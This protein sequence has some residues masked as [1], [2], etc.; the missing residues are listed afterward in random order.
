MLENSLLTCP[1]CWQIIELVIDLSGGS[2]V[3]TEDCPVCCQPM[4]VHVEVDDDSGAFRVD[5]E[6]E[7]D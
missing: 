5:I 1:Y 7:N 4:S 3:Y 2:T 6:R